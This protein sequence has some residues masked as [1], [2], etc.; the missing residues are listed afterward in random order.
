M[1]INPELLKKYKEMGASTTSSKSVL[2]E[3]VIGILGQPGCGKSTLL[4]TASKFYQGY[5]NPNPYNPITGEGL[6]NLSDIGII[7]VDPGSTDGYRSAGYNVDIIRYRKILKEEHNPE[8]AM[9]YAFGLARE[10]PEKEF[11]GLDTVSQFDEDE[12]RFL[13]QNP[14]LYMSKKGNEDTR[15]M[16]NFLRSAHASAYAW[17]LEMPNLKAFV[18]HTKALTDD[19]NSEFKKKDEKELTARKDKIALAGN[20]SITL[21]VTGRSERSWIRINSLLIAVRAI[22]DP[23]TRK[24]ERSLELQYS[25]D[26]DIA[27]KNRFYGLPKNPE[28]NLLKIFNAVRGGNDAA[29]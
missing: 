1:A 11:Y 4:L 22:E 29:A 23:K 16:W 24:M 2:S 26:V 7:Q 5:P 17:L 18:G 8:R 21:D 12:F 28:F 15:E 25:S 27:V 19:L 13:Q 3:S 10:W 20:A 9:E 14:H 6:I